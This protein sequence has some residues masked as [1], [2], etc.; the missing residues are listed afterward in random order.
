MS[1]FCPEK[2]DPET[3]CSHQWS[4]FRPFFPSK[5]I[6]GHHL[7]MQ[8]WTGSPLPARFFLPLS[9]PHP[10]VHPPIILPCPTAS[11]R[12]SFP[13]SPSPFPFPRVSLRPDCAGSPE[14]PL[15]HPP[16]KQRPSAAPGMRVR[17]VLSMCS[18]RALGGSY[19]CWGMG[20]HRRA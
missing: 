17:P 20:T 12:V 10:S 2:A 15:S 5:V 8:T 11:L 7:A 4:P 6:K 14:G 16:C 19:E 13:S 1:W 18:W 9:D 3:S